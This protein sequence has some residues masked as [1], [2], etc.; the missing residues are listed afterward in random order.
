M[1]RLVAVVTLVL[2]ALVPTPSHAVAPV[3]TDVFAIVGVEEVLVQW[4]PLAGAETGVKYVA[5]AM[6]G[7]QSCEV[8]DQE[9]CKLTKLVGGSTI[10][11][12]VV[13]TTKGSVQ[14]SKSLNN[15]IVKAGPPPVTNI[16]VTPGNRKITVSFP[17]LKGAALPDSLG[18]AVRTVPASGTCYIAHNSLN[19]VSTCDIGGLNNGT[20]YDIVVS[21]ESR[22]L[23]KDSEPVLRVRPTYDSNAKFSVGLKP[24]GVLSKNAGTLTVNASGSIAGE[25]CGRIAFLQASPSVLAKLRA[26]WKY[27]SDYLYGSGGELP[28][29]LTLSG[30]GSISGGCLKLGKTVLKGAKALPVEMGWKKPVKPGKY[31]A[32]AMLSY[33]N[34]EFRRFR[35][36]DELVAVSS[37]VPVT[38]R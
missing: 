36:P 25:Y 12:T 24:S 26:D 23:K 32:F 10:S 8:V 16:S 15:V 1:K 31:F 9:Q 2:S 30:Y 27:L 33:A 35:A 28:N 18:Y 22:D 37:L 19:A 17:T 29:G 21:T 34:D 14:F 4:I 5:T 20:Y 3:I 6:P 38:V 13:G 7:G 11:I